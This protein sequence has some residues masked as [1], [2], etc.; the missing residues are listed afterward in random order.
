M[1]ATLR[2]ELPPPEWASHPPSADPLIESRLRVLLQVAERHHAPMSLD[3]LVAHLP[4]GA[5][6]TTDRVVLWVDGHPDSGHV[7]AGHVMPPREIPVPELADRA[8]R[9]ES[10]YAEAEWAVRA[11]LRSAVRLTRCLGV[12]G[13]VAYGFAAP[14]DDLDF[15]V[16]TRRGTTWLFLFLAFASYRLVRRRA[17]P[18]GPSHWCFNYVVDEAEV[19]EEFARPG[20]LLM[21]REAL[22][23]RM[24]RGE[25]YYRSLLREASWMGEELPNVYARRRGPG[26]D[27]EPLEAGVGVLVRAANLLLF[28]LL[29]TYL[30]LTGLVRN[31]RLRRYA[32]EKQFGT[33]T[34]VRRFMLRSL[35]FAELERIYR[36]ETSG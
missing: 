14:N 7:V 36:E 8:S 21:A 23:V 32:P 17:H 5:T 15:F 6:W 2:G 20:G 18:P 28:P 9:S 11:P 24:L 1:D 13:S 4:A 26:T 10:L 34:T 12:S 16:T 29:A 27:P 30:Q 35:R 19:A 22:T 25:A 33:T 31:H 3:Q